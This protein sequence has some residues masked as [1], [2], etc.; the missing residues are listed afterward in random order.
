MGL[1]D[2][3]QVGD[4][5]GIRSLLRR[6]T[7]V[8]KQ[9]QLVAAASAGQSGQVD[10]LFSQDVFAEAT[11]GGLTSIDID[12]ATTDVPLTWLDYDPAA[13]A[14]VTITTSSTGRVAVQ[15][16]GWLGLFSAGFCYA[17]AFI[18]VQVVDATGFEARPP[19]DG[20][21]NMSVEWSEYSYRGTAAT[22][23]RHEW[24]LAPNTRYDL[25]CRR[26]YQVGAGDPAD[27]PVAG[28]YF[29]GTALNVTLIGM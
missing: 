17:H 21:G 22:G 29:Q 28:M 10:F 3:K 14:T 1:L 23:H 2:A 25:R 4:D 27:N 19:L 15:A 24:Q 11:P 16:G 9:L 20:D 13:D 12:P 5:A 8:E 18:G 7:A 6:L 26:G